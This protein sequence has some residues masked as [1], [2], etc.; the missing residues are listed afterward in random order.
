MDYTRV[1]KQDVSRLKRTILTDQLNVA[2]EPE[3]KEVFRILKQKGGI[4][5]TEEIRKSLRELASRL[6]ETCLGDVGK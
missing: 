2:V 5:V 1:M 3:L 6:R 4:N